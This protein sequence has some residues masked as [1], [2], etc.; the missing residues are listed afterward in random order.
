MPPVQTEVRPPQR[1][2]VVFSA[3]EGSGRTRKITEDWHTTDLGKL[4]PSDKKVLAK[5]TDPLVFKF[6]YG[7][8]DHELEM[9]MAIQWKPKETGSSKSARNRASP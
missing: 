3:A 8:E 7:R 2:L 9:H 5:P 6:L 1:T 4:M